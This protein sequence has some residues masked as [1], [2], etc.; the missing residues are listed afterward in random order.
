LIEYLDSND[1]GL[2]RAGAEGRGENYGRKGHVRWADMSKLS[3][4]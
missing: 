1:R 4:Q 3:F 2:I